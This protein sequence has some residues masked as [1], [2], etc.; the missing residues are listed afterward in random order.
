[1]AEIKYRLWFEAASDDSQYKGVFATEIGG[2]RF[3]EAKKMDYS[4]DD[5]QME[6]RWGYFDFQLPF[7]EKKSRVRIGLQ[8]INVNYWLWKETVGAVKLYGDA[9]SCNYKLAWMRG[10]EADVTSE[11]DADLRNDQDAIYGRPKDVGCNPHTVPHRH[12][13]VIFDLDNV[14]SRLGENG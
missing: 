8:P 13:Q 3:G 5:I 14:I 9:G 6:V 12:H 2:L 10:Y 7:A 4:G 1:M 11:I